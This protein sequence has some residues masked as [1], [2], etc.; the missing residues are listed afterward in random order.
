[1]A[2]RTPLTPFTPGTPCPPGLVHV[3]DVDR[4]DD[5]MIE[6]AESVPTKILSVSESRGRTKI[7][8]KARARN[9]WEAYDVCVVLFEGRLV[10]HSCTCPAA[11][12]A[13]PRCNHDLPANRCPHKDEECYPLRLP[14]ACKHIV[15]VHQRALCDGGKRQE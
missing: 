12:F 14:K 2:A 10:D 9:R 6:R 15:A 13:K 5:G 8:A 11:H 7:T 1:M 4:F 3:D